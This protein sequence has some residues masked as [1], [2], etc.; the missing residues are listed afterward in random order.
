MAVYDPEPVIWK[1]S[2]WMWGAWIVASIL[3]V[4]IFND[5]LS[6]LVATWDNREEYSHGYLIPLIVLF[7]I[8]QKKEILERTRFDGS[9]AG[10]AVVLLGLLLYMVGELSTLYV[11]VQYSFLMVVIGLVLSLVGWRAFKKIWVPLVILAFMIPLPNFILRT[12]SAELQLISSQLGVWVIKAFGISVLLEGNVIDLGEYKLQVVEACSGLRYLFPLMT[13][14]FITAYFY[15]AEMWKR[16]LIFLSTIPIT[17]IM[18]SFRIG[19]I[20]VMV[21][22]WGQSMAEGFLHDFEGWVV[23]MACTGVLF[24]EMWLL[25][26]V[27]SDRRPLGSVFAIE[28]PP[29]SEAF[30]EVKSRPLPPQYVGVF[31]LLSMMTIAAVAMPEREEIQ[32]PRKEFALF[33]LFIDGWRGKED[34]LEKIYV[35][36]LKFE[37]YIMAD[38]RNAQQNEVNFYVAYYGSQRKGESAHS[39]RS[40]I[41]GGGW[42]IESLT[43]QTIHD[44]KIHNNP[45]QV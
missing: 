37:D 6:N 35:D 5:G 40:C 9:W 4:V 2:P 22:Y 32:P 41:P 13:F 20:G 25:T 28:M 26:R 15:K 11:V 38:Y 3:L 1:Q 23:F 18:N 14:G 43:Q 12:L 31:V 34:R 24:L 16:A 29:K 19:V 10:V 30:K 33:P 7:L 39:P 36:A 27:G 17:V 44:V 21:E 8:W 45:L 42:Q